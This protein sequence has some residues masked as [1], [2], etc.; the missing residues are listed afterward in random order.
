MGLEEALEALIASEPFE[1]LLLERAR[2]IEAHAGAGQD[3]VIAGLARAMDTS[4]LA[5][6]PGPHEAEAL[7]AEIAA[8]LGAERVGLLPAWEALPY[9]GIGP[10]PEIA[11]RRADAIH[12]LREA[13]GA[14]VV[15]APALAAMQ[16]LIPTLGAIPPLE[17]VAGREL[18]PDALADRLVDLGYARADLIEH[19]GEFA[20]R[21]GVVDVFPGDARR[22]VRLEYWGEEIESLR[23][24]STSTQLS[25]A[26][27]AR[28]LV[29]SVR[30]LIPD[31]EIRA[32]A[33]RRAQLQADR[34][35][36]GLQRMADGL[37][38]EGA[39]T[40]APFVFDHMP[41]V[42][43]LLPHG[44]WVVLT[45]AQRTQD[46]ARQAHEEGEALA[47]A[48]GWPGPHVLHP[49]DEALGEHVRLHLSEFTQG[50]DLGLTDWGSA[51]GNPAELAARLTDLAAAR[52]PLDRVLARPRIA[53]S[54]A[55]V[56]GRGPRR[57]GGR[58]AARERLR[59]GGGHGCRRHRGGL[60]RLSQAHADGAAVH[61]AAA[62]TR[63]RT[64]WS[65][66]T[67]PS[68][69]S[70]ASAA[71]RASRTVRSPVRSATT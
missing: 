1:R 60:L 18:P 61:D 71:T 56:R 44:A 65:R 27:T 16:G 3:A 69:G 68:I 47:E 11:A 55:G 23:E 38:V 10:T 26:K 67:S 5:V 36:D 50:L 54:R 57:R 59:L 64:S 33:G 28:V 6:S 51:Q 8:Y 17:L 15:V 43:E 52:L 4:I 32:L 49:L 34:F 21:G 66:G 70:T 20:V 39:E 2:P 14:F 62:T 25:T 7:A 53:R 35:R 24:F 42:A 29:P 19:R 22:P 12:R 37:F 48:I 63:S 41:T 31:D 9:E 58:G 13:K 45:Q 46:R 30:E 40:L